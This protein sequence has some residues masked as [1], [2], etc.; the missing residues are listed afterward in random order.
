MKNLYR[1]LLLLFLF[2]PF[3]TFAQDFRSQSKRNKKEDSTQAIQA[4]FKIITGSIINEKTKEPLAL[5]TIMQEGTQNGGTSNEQGKFSLKADLTKNNFIIISYFGFETQRIPITAL[6]DNLNIKLVEKFYTITDIVVSVSR[7]NERRYESPVTIETLSAKEI[8]YNPSLNFY[9]RL[10]NLATVDAITTSVNFKTLNT[11]GF[12]STYN[13]RFIQRFDDMDLSMPGF[14]LSV[15]QLNGP[16]DLDV[17]RTELIPGANSALYGP[18]AISG[19]LNTSSK[20]PFIYQGISAE[21]K[22][23]VNHIDRIDNSPQPLYDVNLRMAKAFSEKF[24]AKITMGYMQ[25]AD[26]RATDYRDIGNYDF[27]NNLTSYGFSKGKG[28]PGYDGLNIGGDEVAT[29]ID[30]SVKDGSG[31]APLLPNGPLRVARTGYHED[32]IFHY[33]PYTMK[34]DLGFYFRPTKNIELSLTSRFSFGSSNFQIDNRTQ[35]SDYFLQQHKLELKS[36]NLTVRTYVSAENIGEAI[37]ISLTSINLNRAAKSDENWF[38]QYLFAFSGQYNQLAKGL[39]LDTLR[40]GNDEDARKFADGNNSKLYIPMLI[41][42]GDSA[43]ANLIL[44]NARF[45]PGTP[46]MDSTLAVIKTKPFKN[47]G[48]RIISTSKTWYSEAIYDLSD[49]LKHF[50]LQTGANYRLYAPQTQGSVFN[51]SAQAIYYSEAGL[52]VQAGKNLMQERLKLQGS[53]RVDFFQLFDPKLSPRFSVL[54]QLGEKRQHNFRGSAQIGFRMPALIDIFAQIDA[55]GGLTFGGMLEDA[56]RL[57]LARMK[58][59]GNMQVNLYSRSSV[60]KFK[61]TGDS[62]DL[63]RPVIKDIAPEELRT[64]ELGWRGFL[65]NKLE[66]DVNYYYNSFQNLINAQQFT[67]PTDRTQDLNTKT[68]E[69]PKNTQ[70]YI[71]FMN[72]EETLSSYGYA[73]SATY[74]QSRKW[75]WFGN[76]NYNSLAKGSSI[77]ARDFIFGFNTPKHKINAGFL[78]SKFYKNFNASCNLRWI[79]GFPFQ[80]YDRV[81]DIEAY[82]TLDLMLS[83]TFTKQHTLVKLGGT[84]I[85]NNRYIQAMG[86]PTVGGLYYF[87]IIYDGLIK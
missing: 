41:G 14:N 2:L 85:T 7:K 12:N 77:A 79:D 46:E 5:A 82:Y 55:K 66:L 67:G 22:T 13:R 44:G 54:Y 60:A 53:L 8:Q 19:L 17:E 71:R 80:E 62:N 86:S 4:T 58:E 59:D 57:N 1:H 16:I 15:G 24:A 25:A 32:D 45:E 74:H 68:L 26:W 61:Y 37:D 31:T 56:Y 38:M 48:S 47:D 43:T 42:T 27:S 87:S 73:I 83:Y 84:N 29:I 40:T 78:F 72:M 36:K 11:R 3:L 51:D 20:N 75:T 52:F 10:L 35:I 39:G 23:G 33:Q 49:K 63:I 70:V 9:E 34:T 65:I 69:D 50:N 6:S 18:N 30:T 76:Y 21:I 64:I 81:G 28:N